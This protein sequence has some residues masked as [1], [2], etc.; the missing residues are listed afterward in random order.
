MCVRV[1]ARVRVCVRA[2]LRV[3]V[4]VCVCVCA[5]ARLP[6][7]SCLQ[8][9]RLSTHVHADALPYIVSDALPY[10]VSAFSE[11]RVG[12]RQGSEAEGQGRRH[13]L[14]VCV[15][16]CARASACVLHPCTRA[17]FLSVSTRCARPLCGKCLGDGEYGDPARP[18]SAWVLTASAG[19]GLGLRSLGRGQLAL[20]L[21]CVAPCA[22]TDSTP[23][24]SARSP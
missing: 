11:G 18:R 13:T 20:H 5:R 2:C 10:I 15:S 17:H 24:Q 1:C 23:D 4:C 7:A 6:L 22:L 12:G 21:S 14:C 3:C 19:V 16:A 8:I 9:L